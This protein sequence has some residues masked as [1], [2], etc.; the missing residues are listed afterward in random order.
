MLKICH[1]AAPLLFLLPIDITNFWQ[2]L[3]NENCAPFTSMRESIASYLKR[4]FNTVSM[5]WLTVDRS[6][7]LL[8]TGGWEILNH[9]LIP[10]PHQSL[11]RMLDEAQ[12]HI[13]DASSFIFEV[14]FIL[15]LI[16][17]TSEIYLAIALVNIF[18]WWYEMNIFDAASSRVSWVT[19]EFERSLIF[20]F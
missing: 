6:C 11:G 7:I 10:I 8:S 9:S 1:Y 17:Q 5:A 14:S 18:I 20:V 12:V 15:F 16:E 13:D 4:S 19:A 3:A 2:I